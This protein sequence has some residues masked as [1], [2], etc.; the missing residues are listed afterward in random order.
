MKKPPSA[1]L[2]PRATKLAPVGACFTDRR[3]YRST[4]YR[5]GS[6]YFIKAE[7]FARFDPRALV[8]TTERPITA[9]LALQ[10]KA[11]HDAFRAALK[12]EA[13]P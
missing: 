10:T 1:R 4:L 6:R 11:A 7:T 9:R 12:G 13:Q 5:Q 8:R 3:D 2:T